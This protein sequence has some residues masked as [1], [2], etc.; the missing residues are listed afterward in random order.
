MQCVLLNYDSFRLEQVYKNQSKEVS[1]AKIRRKVYGDILYENAKLTTIQRFSCHDVLLVSD[2]NFPTV[3][4]ENRILQTLILGR[5]V[6]DNY[7]YPFSP[8]TIPKAIIFTLNTMQ[9]GFADLRVDPIFSSTLLIFGNLN[10]DSVRISCFACVNYIEQP[11][12]NPDPL[13]RSSTELFEI[14]FVKLPANVVSSLSELTKYWGQLHTNFKIGTIS[15]TTFC[16]TI[17]PLK[18]KVAQ[19]RRSNNFRYDLCEFS[20]EYLRNVN[21]TYRGNFP[22]FVT[23]RH[24]SRVAAGYRKFDYLIQILPLGQNQIE[25]FIQLLIFKKEHFD[26]N[27]SAF[28][29]PFTMKIWIFTL[30][31]I[32]ITSAWLIQNEGVMLDHTVFWQIS[33]VLAQG[34]GDLSKLKLA[35][36]I[37]TV[38]WLFVAIL[39]REFYNS[40]LYSF[41]AAEIEQNDFPQ[42]I[43]EVLDRTEYDLILPDTFYHQLYS[44]FSGS[45]L[46]VPRKLTK[47]YLKIL[48]KSFFMQPFDTN[49][50]FLYTTMENASLGINTNVYHFPKHRFSSNVT[51]ADIANDYITL[52]VQKR[53]SQF[54]VVCSG[55]CIE[56]W[57]TPLL[58]QKRLQRKIPKQSSFF[59]IFEFW[60]RDRSFFG[61]IHFPRFL[62]AFVQA[63]L[64]ELWIKRYRMLTYLNNLR[65]NNFVQNLNISDGRL[66]SYVVFGDRKNGLI[67]NINKTGA[68]ASS[69]I[70]MFL[71]TGSTVC[72]AFLVLIFE[73]FKKKLINV[74]EDSVR[75]SCFPC[76]YYARRLTIRPDPKRWA[77]KAVEKVSFV[78][79]PEKAISS[80]KVLIRYWV[81][82][83]TKLKIGYLQDTTIC[84]TIFPFPLKIQSWP[85]S[86]FS[87]TDF[88]EICR[89][90]LRLVNITYFSNYIFYGLSRQLSR[91]VLRYEEYDYLTQ[92]LPHGQYQVEFFVQIFYFKKDYFDT[93][94]SAFLIPFTSKV[95]VCTLI[96][97]GFTSAWLIQSEGLRASQAV[98]WQVSVILGQDFGGLYKVKLSSKFLTVFWMFAAIL[99]REFYNSSLSSF[100]AA[101]RDQQDFPKN[102]QQVLDMPD[103]DLIVS[104]GDNNRTFSFASV[105]DVSHG[106]YM[107]FAVVC[108]EDCLEDRNAPLLQHSILKLAMPKQTAFFRSFEFWTRDRSLYGTIHFPQF[109]GAFVQA[110]LYEL[111]IKRY[112]MFSH[113]IK[114]KTE[115]LKQ[116]FGISDGRLYS[117]VVFGNKKSC[118]AVNANEIEAKVSSFVGLFLLTGCITSSS[119]LVLILSGCVRQN[120]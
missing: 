19:N 83:H 59:S 12:H 117:Y 54:A 104:A 77:S 4:W 108:S 113:L 67:D 91:N 74:V 15:D 6:K 11:I 56:N 21:I 32:L 78:K 105:K 14:S 48:E 38:I 52:D 120:L 30:T 1:K 8:F 53:F 101:G 60:G 3:N 81:K 9:S 16:N 24:L 88:C 20:V 5:N 79:V 115:N 62:R 51:I 26:T 70:G 18:H 37:I 85:K 31:T 80:L 50:H 2:S 68:K 106:I 66:Y 34:V 92:I 114:L 22:F 96:T 82:L 99:L 57:L 107:N 58:Q 43:E 89:E 109:L 84:S 28:L 23:A 47:M 71:L 95:W 94:L 29:T 46:E 40:T 102:I 27:L 87:R 39:L 110:G 63:G 45:E 73:L 118:P 33:V 55:D 100:M 90:Y 97:I 42:N 13:S 112:R 41:M 17:F 65:F 116:D 93:N 35:T 49:G 64:Y 103:Y 119:F 69:F 86:H 36:K 98:F 111:L 75:I 76:E 10:D 61:T 44:V 72:V 7:V 25:F